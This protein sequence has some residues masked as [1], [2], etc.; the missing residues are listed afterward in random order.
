MR[1]E[2]KQVAYLH[3]ASPLGI[4]VLGSRKSIFGSSE[5]RVRSRPLGRSG[6]LEDPGKVRGVVWGLSPESGYST[7]AMS[8]EHLGGAQQIQRH[9]GPLFLAGGN[10]LVHRRGVLVGKG[11]CIYD[12][13]CSRKGT[14]YH[15]QAL[16]A[17]FSVDL[18]SSRV[19]FPLQASRHLR[20]HCL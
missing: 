2:D 18:N 13:L 3:V 7:G 17:L 9:M 19:G 14:C 20:G 5:A 8:T 4:G 10:Y 1:L 15:V 12:G 6:R 16:Q 11:F